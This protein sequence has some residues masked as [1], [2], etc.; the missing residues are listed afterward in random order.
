[1][2]KNLIFIAIVLILL[3]LWTVGSYNNFVSLNQKADNQWAQVETQYQRRYDLIPNL[4]KSVEGIMKQEQQVFKDLANARTNYAGAKTVDEKTAAASEI[5]SSLSR[6]LVIVENYPE[7]KSNESVN[8]LMDELSGTENRVAVERKRFNDE[9]T[10]YN[11]LAIKFPTNI[12]AKLF[13]FKSRQLF[14][15]ASAA[16]TAPEVK[17]N[18]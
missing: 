12:L 2:K 10:S 18:Q 6:L 17:F 13:G 11:M 4:V 3:A 9:V 16:Q 7:L 1:M 8:K 14:E 15:A 5:E